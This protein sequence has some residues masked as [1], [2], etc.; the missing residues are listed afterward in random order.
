MLRTTMNYGLPVYWEKVNIN[1]ITVN[2]IQA[3]FVLMRKKI[4]LS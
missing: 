4:I 3:S 2:D 1:E